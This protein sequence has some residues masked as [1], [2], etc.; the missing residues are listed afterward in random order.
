ML[1]FPNYRIFRLCLAANSQSITAAGIVIIAPSLAYMEEAY[2]DARKYGWARKPIVEK[3]RFFRAL[4]RLSPRQASMSRVV[5]LSM[6]R[7]NCRTALHGT[8]IAMKSPIS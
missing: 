5:L 4:I 6:S 3:R 7:R 2:F 1:R 8:I